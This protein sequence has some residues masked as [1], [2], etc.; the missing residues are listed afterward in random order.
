MEYITRD[1][2]ILTGKKNLESLY[3]FKDFPV[4]MGCTNKDESHD[5][6][7]DM[8]FAICPETGIIQLDKLL[9]LDLVYQ[10]QHNDGVGKVWQEHYTA[11]ADFLS[12]FSPKNVLEIGGSHDVIA[13]AFLEK[14]QETQWTMVEPHPLFESH[15][16][17]KVISQWFDERFVSQDS[18]DAVVHSHVLE[19]MYD[20]PAFMACIGKFLAP[21]KK[22]IFTF[23]NFIESFKKKYTNSL[24]FEHTCF[25]AEPFVDYLLRKNGFRII[26]KRYFQEHSIFYATEKTDATVSEK[27][28]PNHYVEYKKLFQDFIAYHENLVK[29]LNVKIDTFEGKVYMFGAHIF[30][31]CLFQFG[32]KQH[33]ITGI[34]DNSVLKGGKRLYGTSL[35]VSSPEIL[36]G[37]EKVAVVLKVAG[38]RDEIARQLLEIN[39]HIVIFE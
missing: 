1:Q 4:F 9:S 27:S 31:Q 12:E 14:N 37:K 29:K 34:L 21:G 8:S 17:I 11:F 7:A 28:M 15:G 38:Y 18:Y 10:A 30:S 16:R 35:T 3:V 33:T 25:L 2:S 6:K 19:H 32:L 26:D 24:N 39:P 5:I 23:P 36:R 22:H 20:P 13:N